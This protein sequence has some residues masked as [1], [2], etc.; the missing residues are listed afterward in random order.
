[1][2][3]PPYTV[4]T[5]SNNFWE[6]SAQA[7]PLTALDFML[8][9]AFVVRVLRTL[10]EQRALGDLPRITAVPLFIAAFGAGGSAASG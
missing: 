8:S 10:P 9:I 5:P 1:L 7:R 4:A 3:G 2:D 6:L